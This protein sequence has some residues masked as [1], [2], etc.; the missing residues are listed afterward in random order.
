MTVQSLQEP[1]SSICI[2]TPGWETWSL[3]TVVCINDLEGTVGMYCM[4]PTWSGV[5][6]NPV[7]VLHMWCTYVFTVHT[8]WDVSIYSTPNSSCSPFPIPHVDGAPVLMRSSFCLDLGIHQELLPPSLLT[9]LNRYT[10]PGSTSESEV[11]II[12]AINSKPLLSVS[13]LVLASH[14]SHHLDRSQVCY[15][16]SSGR[17]LRVP[18][19]TSESNCTT[20]GKLIG[21]IS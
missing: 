9:S 4:Y 16:S 19:C 10:V 11:T 1:D 8:Y 21:R 3:S 2:Q 6:V 12:T 7:Q 18:T 15:K 17:D 20:E 5:T 13:I 14:T